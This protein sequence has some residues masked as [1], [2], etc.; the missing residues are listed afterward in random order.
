M[1]KIFD[2]FEKFESE[3]ALVTPKDDKSLHTK[4]DAEKVTGEVASRKESTDSMTRYK[5][6]YNKNP[7]KN[8]IVH[9]D[10]SS[11]EA[12]QF[13]I[14]RTMILFPVSGI[15]PRTIMITSALPE[16]GKSFVASNLAVSMAQ[17]IN[18]HVLLI[19][20]DIRKP[21]L[22]NS[23]GFRDVPGLSEH[24]SEG[25]PLSSLILQTMTHKLSLLPAGAP[26]HNP[27]ELLSSES[28]S[29]L[30][31]EVK[32]RYHDRYII[33]DTP[34]PRLTAETG[35]LSRQVDGIIVVINSEMTPKPMVEKLVEMVGKEKILGIVMNRFDTRG[36]KYYAYGK[37]GTYSIY[38]HKKN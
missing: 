20:G 2:A 5:R 29:C 26:P 17:N 25:R 35:A 24:L 16:E 13:K 28:M 23:F 22:H 6:R 11:Y 8:L 7:D 9:N 36:S 34:P 18:E 15:R 37:Y 14:L 4:V 12:E 32:E 21:S 3:T 38:G 19:D 10:P 33:L 30:I 27:S 31:Q 1:G